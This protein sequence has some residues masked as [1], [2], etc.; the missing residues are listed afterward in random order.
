MIPLKGFRLIYP[1]TADAAALMCSSKMSDLSNKSANGFW[2]QSWWTT[3]LLKI[4][5]F[6]DFLILRAKTLFLCL[7][8][9]PLTC[10]EKEVSSKKFRLGYKYSI[11]KYRS[12]KNTQL[13]IKYRRTPTLMKSHSKHWTFSYTHCFLLSRKPDSIRN[14]LAKIPLRWNLWISFSCHV[15]ENAFEIS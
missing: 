5:G 6:T 1:Y 11:I 15:F 13:S 8:I 9:L 2:D 12:K 3:L 7:F 4:G 14:K 10:Q